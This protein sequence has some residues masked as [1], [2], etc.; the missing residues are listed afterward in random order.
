MLAAIRTFL[1][2]LRPAKPGWTEAD[3]RDL[4]DKQARH[5]RSR[6]AFQ[7]KQDAKHAELAREVWG[8]PAPSRW[9]GAAR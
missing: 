8:H 2:A 3:E 7:R 1:N 9:R 4:R 5:E 6:T